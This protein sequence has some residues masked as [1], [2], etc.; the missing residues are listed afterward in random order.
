[1]GPWTLATAA[2]ASGATPAPF[3]VA[4]LRADTVY[5]VRVWTSLDADDGPAGARTVRTLFATPAGV[6][7]DTGAAYDEPVPSLEV[8]PASPHSLRL[9]WHAPSTGVVP[10]FY[11]VPNSV[12][13]FF[14]ILH[15][16]H[17]N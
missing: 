11:T 8:A 16:F 4:D 2:S 3:V 6:D 17:Q 1:M 12:F 13:S 14:F 10:I 5:E 9:E 7:S 15:V